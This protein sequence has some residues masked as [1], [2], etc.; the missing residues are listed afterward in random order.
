M[1]VLCAVEE[2][3]W[4]N[5]HC[6]ITLHWFKTNEKSFVIYAENSLFKMKLSIVLIPRGDILH[7]KTNYM[8]KEHEV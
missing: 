1:Q 6:N 7:G 8:N 5:K 3:L 2:D 4:E